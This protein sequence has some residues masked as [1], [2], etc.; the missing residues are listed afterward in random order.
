MG[1]DSIEPFINYDKGVFI[2]CLTS[3]KG[4]DNFQN[5]IIKNQ[6]LYIHVSKLALDLNKNN[7][8]GLV[9]GATKNDK[10]KRL[11]DYSKGLPWLIPGVGFQGG[12][13]E[14]SIQIGSSFNSLPI[15]NVSRGIIFAGSGNLK[16]INLACENYTKKIRNLL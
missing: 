4:S 13:L 7:N 3:N 16:D 11:R 15:I 5:Q 6:E 12:S 9:V 10:M 1:I 14:D 8:I 2:L